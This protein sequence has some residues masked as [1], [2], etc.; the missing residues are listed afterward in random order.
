MSAPTDYAI[1]EIAIRDWA[2]TRTALT[3]LL[4]GDTRLIDLT[5]HPTL[6]CI[7]MYRAGGA[8]LANVP[9]D[10]PTMAFQCWGP[11]GASTVTSSPM[12]AL[13]LGTALIAEINQ[14]GGK[15]MMPGVFALD[16][17]VLS[18]YWNP[19]AGDRPRYVVNATIALRRSA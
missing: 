5:P 8:P 17:T 19:G 11:G 10:V 14:M 9:V 15:A 3:T 12:S 13:R 16:G 7:G 4:S 1:A 6:P 18:F 2:R